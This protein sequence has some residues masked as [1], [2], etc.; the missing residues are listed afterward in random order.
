MCAR[1]NECAC[2]LGA[3]GHYRHG[4][5]QN[6]MGAIR[7]ALAP[8]GANTLDPVAIGAATP[9]GYNGVPADIANGIVFLASEESRYM[10][11]AE[12]VID[13]GMTAK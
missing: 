11:G 7:T 6:G 1:Q 13:G 9:I 2:E 5:P 10:T 3:S 12:L 4:D 8:E